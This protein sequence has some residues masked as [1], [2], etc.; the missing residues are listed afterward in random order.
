[1]VH[2]TSA[3]SAGVQFGLVGIVESDYTGWQ[4]YFINITK[5]RFEGLQWG[6]YNYA[7]TVS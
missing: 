1:L 7:A 6:F 5:D 4:A 2:V 3:A